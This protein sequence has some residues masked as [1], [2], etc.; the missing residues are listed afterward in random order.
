VGATEEPT[1]FI[2]RRVRRSDSH[3]VP[4]LTVLEGPELGAFHAFDPGR[5]AHRIG[6]ADEADI[7]LPDPSVSRI[8]AIC[9]VAERQDRFSVRIEDNGSTNGVMV[10]GRTVDET[11]LISGDKVRLGDILLRFEWMAE[12]EVRYHSN[13]SQK[14]RAGER[15]HL[16]GMLTRA[17]LDERL[18]RLIDE[19]ERRGQTLS[20]LL[21]DLDHFK[22]INDLHGHLVGD[23]VIQRVAEMLRLGLRETDFAV[24]YGGEEFLVVM[25]GLDL[26]EAEA[27]ASRLR[28]NLAATSMHDLSAGLAVTTSIGVAT[29]VRGEVTEDWIERADQA[30]YDAKRLGRDRVVASPSPA[31][32]VVESSADEDT[33]P[34]L[35]TLEEGPETTDLEGDDDH[36]VVSVDDEDER[37]T[38]GSLDAVPGPDS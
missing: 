19:V 7:F 25:P 37:V 32:P 30:L 1:R 3:L 11:S 8:H 33:S 13:V 6:R 4:T 21:L 24:R 27:V 14:V 29:R 15:D 16:S 20:C 2:D 17:F 26:R 36:T 23:G 10:N 35:A 5:R 38:A 22:R 9:V 12:E 34:A 28:E 31:P 18:E